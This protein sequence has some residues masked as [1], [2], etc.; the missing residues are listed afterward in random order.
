M[1][2]KGGGLSFEISGENKALLQVL[3]QSKTAIQDTTRAA[4]KGG[5]DMD[6]AFDRAAQAIDKGFEQAQRVI[7]TNT[8]TLRELR[9][10]Y[11][12]LKEAAAAAYN[13]GDDHTYAVLNEQARVLQHE[14]TLRE[15]LVQQAG[16]CCD[17]LLAEEQTLNRQKEAY[18]KNASASASLKSQLRDCVARLAEMEAAGKRDTDEFRQLQ[19]EAGRLTDAISDARTQARIF[20]H[21][22]ANLQGVISGVQG[23]AGAFTMAQGAMALFGEENEDLQRTM[24]KLQSVMSITMGLQQVYNTLNKDSAFMLTT[25]TAVKN[26]LTAANARLAVALGISTVA[27]QALM[28]S[29][30]FGLS[31]AITA[32]IALISKFSSE[33]A[34]AKK[35]QE[36]FNKAVADA[37]GEPLAAY[38]ALQE[39][40]LSLTDDMKAREKW[41]QDNADKFDKLGVSV[42]D[43]KQAEDLLI[44]NAPK[45]VEACILKAKALAAQ[46]LAAEKYKEILTKQAEYEGMSDKVTRIITN[47]YG[48]VAAT[49]EV[50]NT[51]KKDL[52]KEIDAMKAEADSFIKQQVQF[53]KEEQAILAEIGQGAKGVVAGSVNEAEQ[54]LSR[55]QKL[56]KNAATDAERD[57]LYRQIEEQ[58][59]KVDKLNRKSTGTGGGGN[60][61]GST[62]KD[63]FVE[64]LNNRRDAYKKYATWM[65]SEDATVRA[66]ATKE[67]AEILKD[68]NSYIDYLEK[69]RD[70]LSAK[71]KKTATDLKNLSTINNEIANATKQTVLDDF[72]KQLSRELEQCNTIAARLELLE[73]KRA[74]LA[75]DN[76]DLDNAKGDVIKEAEEATKQQAKEETKALLQEYSGYLTEK[77]EFE[78]NYA[79]RRQLLELARSKATNDAE[80]RQ[81][82]A[83]L[84]A[85]EAKRKEYA[86]RSDSEQYDELLQTYKTFQQQ[87]DEITKKYA[88]QRTLAEKQGNLAMLSQINA[89]EQAELSKLATE[90]LKASESWN[91]LFSDLSTLSAKTINKLI[92]DI[93][94]QKVQLSAQ[95]N[96]ADLKAIQDQ[97]DKAKAEIHK[98]NPFIALKD[99]LA[100]LRA[101]MKSQK[102]LDDTD[103]GK[104]L[105]AL[106]A[107]YDKYTAAINSDDATLANSAK[108]IYADLLKQGSSY[109]DALR[110]KL[111]ELQNTK[112]TIGL[113]VKGEEQLATIEAAIKKEEGATKTT[114]EALKATFASTASSIGQVKGVFDSVVGGM[115]KMGITMDEETEVILNDIGGMMEGAEQLAQGI[116]TSNPLAIIQGSIGLFTSV[117][118]MFNSGDRKAERSIKKHEQA[119]KRLGNAYNQLEHQVKRALGEETYYH[120]NAEIANLRKQQEELQ[121]MISDESGKKH[122]DD[123]RIAEWQEQIAEAGRQIEDI[124][125]EIAA[126]ITQT[127]GKDLA[128]E[129][130]DALV[131]AF[132]AG[133]DAAEVFGDV[134]NNAIKNAVKNA[135]KLQFL[136][137]P[138]Q[139]AIA[140]LQ[141]DMGFDEEGNG[142]FDGLTEKEQQAFKNAVAAAGAN[143]QEA[144]KVYKDLFAGLDENDPSSL[145]GAIKGAS[146]ESIDLLAGQTNAVRVN[147]TTHIALVREQLTHLAS[148]DNRLAIICGNLTTIIN[149]LSDNSD[150]MR[151]QGINY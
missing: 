41:V 35:K 57:K 135:L 141:K 145:S 1:N 11:A 86:G 7:D 106:K 127:T 142:S 99:S 33:S 17:E 75:N 149:R 126:N 18:E 64:M 40:W 48:G 113:D 138:L 47:Q 148:M 68:G 23:V 143:F 32:I 73:R 36:E 77:L 58:Q 121:G 49:Y 139:A 22:N 97:L 43:A 84:E 87:K 44:R 151:A 67:F 63:P 101:A 81:A 94:S 122:S 134:A 136:E 125:D 88:E 79:R 10:E 65:Q 55:L 107:Q 90:R 132:E 70:A 15:K 69:M 9:A 59:K 104:E 2:I 53:S 123:D 71:T 61:S 66:A 28:A 105:Q 109:L 26:A 124:M 112:L 120:Q 83:A 114:G 51:A 62:P 116:A 100:E 13:S 6:A 37:A 76:S 34:K 80:R 98:R 137:K 118:D 8:A 146:Q 27:A 78:A 19:R 20:S 74:E 119:I 85:L 24:V 82:E 117:Y 95:F 92:A 25:V 5:K 91:Q 12:R 21:D 108:T 130:A 46:N 45:F 72:T 103:Y 111:A 30:T 60:G 89:A 38:Y 29:L 4:T 31:V 133:T 93:N 96:P 110:R 52:K 129:L 144:M 54:E 128:N 50:E 131:E 3:E 16:E 102:L 147:Q 56:Y 14:I 140:Q 39:E 115:K 42:Q 150:P